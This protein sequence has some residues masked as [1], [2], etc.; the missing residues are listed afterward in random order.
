VSGI[1][2]QAERICNRQSTIYNLQSS[3]I[4]PKRHFILTVLLEVRQSPRR[5]N[6]KRPACLLVHKRPE[7]ASETFLV[8]ICCKN[9]QSPVPFFI[10]GIS[11]ACL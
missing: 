1:R 6:F 9:R 11:G 5:I 3:I 2:F 4:N 7:P 10:L 8:K